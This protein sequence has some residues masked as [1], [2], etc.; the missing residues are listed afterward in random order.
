MQLRVSS[1]R[2]VCIGPRVP[3]IVEDAICRYNRRALGL[4]RTAIGRLVLEANPKACSLDPKPRNQPM[5]PRQGVS[6]KA[7][8]PSG[9]R[10]HA[11]TNRLSRYYVDDSQRKNASVARASLVFAA[12]KKEDN[13]KQTWLTGPPA[14][15]NRRQRRCCIV[16]A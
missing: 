1:L 8:V 3:A 9:T 5:H 7:A 6:E 11:M 4:H 2:R 13:A 10:R 16:T 12:A 15:S 14:S